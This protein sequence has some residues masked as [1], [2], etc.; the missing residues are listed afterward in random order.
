MRT[1]FALSIAG[2][3]FC[4][5]TAL[6]AQDDNDED[7]D[8]VSCLSMNLVR[9]ANA[10]DDDTVLFELR[11]GDMFISRLEQTCLGLRRNNRFSYNLRSGARIPRLC[12]TDT[13]TVIETS[14]DGFTC[15][16]GRFEPVSAAAIDALIAR[17]EDEAPVVTV[18]EVD[19]TET[20]DDEARQDAADQD[21]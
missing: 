12:H 4:L 18:T 2:A 14:G 11:N 3:G 20:A 6:F 15:G 21:E 17:P 19:V 10:I 9:S 16:L 1:R 13:I 7:D 8:S 5:A